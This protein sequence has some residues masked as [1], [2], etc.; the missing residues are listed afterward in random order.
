MKG[1]LVNPKLFLY[2]AVLFLTARSFSGPQP[3]KP[4][5]IPVEKELPPRLDPALYHTV[6]MEAAKAP[7][8]ILAAYRNGGEEQVL[9]FFTALCGSS[10]LA[11]LILSNASEYDI[12]PALAFALCWEESRYYKF[13]V[14]R[15]KNDSVDR[16]LF[17]LNSQSFPELSAEDFFNPEINV[18]YA[19]AHLR[20]CLD[21]GGSE[22]SGLAMYNVGRGRVNGG[23]APKATLDYIS[24]IMGYRKGIVELFNTEIAEQPDFPVR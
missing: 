5:E 15:N 10:E 2:G 24:R 9:A 3:E 7:D 21:R 14:N 11:A 6:A 22:L 23:G 19:M 4:E 16:G 20:W 18:R 12:E 8:P 17:Q 1:A 13:A